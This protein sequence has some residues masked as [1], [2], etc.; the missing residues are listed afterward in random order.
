MSD[1]S[2][3][4]IAV[5]SLLLAF[6]GAV[7]LWFFVS[8]KEQGNMM[9]TRL[10]TLELAHQQLALRFEG[11]HARHDE[12]LENLTHAIERLAS[13]IERIEGLFVASGNKPRAR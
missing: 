11:S 1:M 10:N 13:K 8:P 4:A 6:V 2:Q 5:W 12:S 3:E 9:A 7:I